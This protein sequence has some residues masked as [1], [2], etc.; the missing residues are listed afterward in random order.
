MTTDVAV[1]LVGLVGT[2]FT[3]AATVAAAAISSLARRIGQPANGH[4]SLAEQL[5][6]LE[7][8]LT[9]HIHNDEQMFSQILHRAKGES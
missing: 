9:D 1:A 8:R 3:A 6:A 4:R 2:V 5:A 7:A